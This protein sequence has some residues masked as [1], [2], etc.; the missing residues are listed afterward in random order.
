MMVSPAYD[1][2]HVLHSSRAPTTLLFFLIDQESEGKLPYNKSVC[3]VS[4]RWRE[5][6]V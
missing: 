1:L 5:G 4:G 3:R 2:G 6:W